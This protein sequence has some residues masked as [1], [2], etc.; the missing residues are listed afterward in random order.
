MEVQLLDSGK[1]KIYTTNCNVIFLIVLTTN[2][3]TAS[4]VNKHQTNSSMK[5]SIKIDDSETR[6][7]V[8]YFIGNITF[9]NTCNSTF[10]FLN[11]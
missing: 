6:A 4:L 10:L 9:E 5:G 2:T 8:S 3:T 7:A 1:K 11:K